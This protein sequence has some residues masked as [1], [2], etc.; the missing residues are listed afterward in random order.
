ML[1]QQHRAQGTDSQGQAE[2]LMCATGVAD[3]GNNMP[4]MQPC[5]IKQTLCLLCAG[6]YAAAM[7]AGEDAV[8]V[9]L[10]VR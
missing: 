7:S 8:C 3:T 9:H 2:L 10:P 1:L 4:Q 6:T 5:S